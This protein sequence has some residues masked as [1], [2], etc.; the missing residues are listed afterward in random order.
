[1]WQVRSSDGRIRTVTA[2]SHQGAIR[3]YIDAHD[4][5]IGEILDVKLRGAEPDDES[6]G[7]RSYKIKDEG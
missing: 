6:E 3:E 7:W 4:P 2:F 1:M 5:P